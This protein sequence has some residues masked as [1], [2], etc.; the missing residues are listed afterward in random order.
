MA[1]RFPAWATPSNVKKGLA[2]IGLVIFAALALFFVSV[3]VYGLISGRSPSDAF[4]MA[5]FFTVLVVITPFS[6]LTTGRLP[7]IDL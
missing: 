6:L 3:F 5:A 7:Y 2:R 1:T 4:G